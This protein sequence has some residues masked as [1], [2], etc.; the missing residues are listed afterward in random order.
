M[1]T[2]VQENYPLGWIPGDDPINGRAQ[3]LL[4]MDNLQLEEKGIVSLQ[5]G[6]TPIQQFPGGINSIYSRQLL[7]G[8]AR[9]V[10]HGT[11][12]SRQ[13]AG[14]VL[15][16]GGSYGAAFATVWGHILVAS[17]DE[18]K[19]DD[20]TNSVDLAIAAPAAPTLSVN[21]PFFKLLTT[22]N[23]YGDWAGVETDQAADALLAGPGVDY[24][25]FDLNT[26]SLRG[27]AE[28]TKDNDSLALSS[29]AVG[30]DN[31]IFSFSI[32]CQDTAKVSKVRLE[33][34]LETPGDDVPDYFLQEWD[35]HDNTVF[36][37]TEAVVTSDPDQTG[38]FKGIKLGS[39]FRQ[40][41]DVWNVLSCKRSDF[42]RLG[43]DDSKGWNTIKGIRLVVLGSEAGLVITATTFK[44][45]GGDTG[46]LRGFYR[47]VALNIFEDETFIGKSPTGAESAEVQAINASIAVTPD[48]LP[49]N[50]TKKWVY[51]I[52]GKL[53]A[54]Y[55]VKDDWTTGT[56]ND[57]ISDDDLIAQGDKLD[58]AVFEAP[59]TNII[60]IVGPVRDRVLYFTQTTVHFSDTNDPC[61]VNVNHKAELAASD[62]EVI[63]FAE[64]V[65]EDQ[66]LVATTKD[67]YLL[68][69]GFLEDPDT[70]FLDF[71]L[72]AYGNKFPAMNASHAIDKGIV[73]YE[74]A[75][76]I[77]A[78]QGSQTDLLSH[79]LQLLFNK[80]ARADLLSGFSPSQGIGT[81]CIN[82][83]AVAHD[84]L[85][86]VGN[87]DVEGLRLFTYHLT[88]KY[89][90]MKVLPGN[91]FAN[92]LFTEESGSLLAGGQ[93]PSDSFLRIIDS[94]GTL[95]DGSVSQIFL[96]TTF[97]N[98]GQAPKRRKDAYTLKV[99]A[100]T[101]GVGIQIYVDA[102]SDNNTV[103]TWGTTIA[104]TGREEK[105]FDIYGTLA[106]CK[107]F[108][109]RMG[110]VVPTFRLYLT[111]IEYEP[112]PEQTSSI[113]LK[114]TNL[115]TAKRKKFIGVP[116]V[117]DTLS[118]NITISVFV[119]G[120]LAGSSN[121]SSASKR[122]L[123]HWFT[124]DVTGIDCE[125]L[126]TAVD[127]TKVF[128]FYELP[129]R[130]AVY[131]VLPLATKFMRIN[132]Q[133]WG[134]AARKRF[135]RLSFIIDPRGVPVNITPILDGVDGPTLALGAGSRKQTI[136]YFYTGDKTPV[137]IGAKLSSTQEFEFYEMLKP[138][139][140]EVLPE[141]VKFYLTPNEN[142]GTY[143]RKR[144][145][146][147]SLVIDS[148]NTSVDVVPILDGVAQTPQTF[149]T[150]RKATIAYYFPTDVVAR[151]VG[152]Q[153]SG[154]NYFEF[155]NLI[156]PERMEVL[157]EPV[158]FLRPPYTNYGVA[159]KKRI[160]T[161]P[162][163]IDTRGLDVTYIPN[164]DGADFIPAT[165]N[166]TRK[167]T[168]FYY[169]ES[170]MFGIDVGGQ[171]SAAGE[172]E[173]YQF[174]QPEKVEVL[175][176]GKKLDQLGPIEFNRAG[177][178]RRIRIRMVPEGTAMSYRL[179]GQDLEIDSGTFETVPGKERVYELS[180]IKGI[181]A[182]IC[183]LE[184]Q[185]TSVF[186]R[187][188]AEFMV[189]TGAQG[190]EWKKLKVS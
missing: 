17:G 96:L 185:S 182:T 154:A 89:W 13:G 113:R 82:G 104:F 46:P 27:I 120:V 49:A 71:A 92:T 165:F 179:Y 26:D 40:G 58:P 148:R 86:W 61:R 102:Y 125:T 73:F 97:Y 78:T 55:K 79:E 111:A 174:E 159:A 121:N 8:L 149:T 18:R 103:T 38:T 28:Q 107:Y 47:Y 117:I 62:G 14:T 109:I 4:R 57:E 161:I 29:S 34:L 64:Q 50:A 170:D 20:G 19:R 151:E 101:G 106:T 60:S 114:G 163:V 66:I 63:V 11:T 16:G 115:G 52:G 35:L 39:S 153:I 171:F 142:F 152:F 140:L 25:Q 181:T 173:F 186:Y 68:S 189:D 99:I 5:N 146:R 24:V 139:I 110:G 190:T 155:Y 51:R 44:F 132:E 32:R 2:I 37:E 75:D 126:I 160:R 145:N 80:E 59:P 77:R 162:L 1:A 67:F 69:G 93:A 7:S 166:T 10:H 156:K 123:F 112:R 12:V 180:L 83:L 118:N 54:Y 177:R 48:A 158:T 81:P 141:P 116:Y 137:D 53:N 94:P 91:A 188:N 175:P 41:L 167:Q 72:H 70:G 172:F 136:N 128:E 127:P 129:E 74:A 45:I 131:E 178:V 100:D 147:L 43:T 88:Q 33:I 133:N 135:S 84:K 164:V 30:T 56:F 119:D 21:A 76:G 42:T 134:T 95:F 169:F 176:V 9:Y 31:D 23:N 3:G 124:T 85:Y 65:A 187:I 168:V 122:T 183:R 138:E 157:P 184:L 15:T 22:T 6:T 130:D 105:S 90:A 98:D 150:N 143:A 144:F 108:R 36:D 87:L